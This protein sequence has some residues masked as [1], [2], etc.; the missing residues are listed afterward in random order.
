[1]PLAAALSNALIAFWVV[2]RASSKS[3]VSIALRA[4]FIEERPPVKTIMQAA[5]AFVYRA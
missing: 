4:F 1:M 3:P 2:T 5:L